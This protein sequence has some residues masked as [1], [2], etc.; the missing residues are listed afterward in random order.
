MDDMGWVVD[1]W[2][3]WRMTWVGWWIQA[4][5]LAGNLTFNPAVDML[6][7]ENGD[8]F[9]LNSPQDNHLPPKGFVPSH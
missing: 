7:D 6:A 3:G 2:V 9:G 4:I 5:S 8:A 1:S